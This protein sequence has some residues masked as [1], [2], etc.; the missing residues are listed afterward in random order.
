MKEPAFWMDGILATSVIEI[1]HDPAIL[2]E[3]SHEGFWAV[4]VNFEGDWT[5]VRFADIRDSPFP[6][7]EWSP[8]PA[9]WNSTLDEVEYRNYVEAIREAIAAGDFYQVNAC[10][11]LSRSFNGDLDG[12]FSRI[13][14]GNPAPYSAYFKVGDTEIASASP[15]LFLKMRSTDIGTSLTSSP[16]KGTSIDG[17]FGEKDRS[18]NVMIVDLIRNDLSQICEEGSVDVSRLLGVEEHP[19]LFHLVSDVTGTLKKDFNW[20]DFSGALLPAGSISGAPK[21][22]AIEFIQSHEPQ[23]G[24]YCGILGYIDTRGGKC[25]ALL[26]VAIRI[27]WLDK[28][29]QELKFGSGAGITWGSDPDGEWAET[30]L[31][32]SRLMRIA[33]G[34][35]VQ[36]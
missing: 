34:E 2:S 14:D 8:T 30:Q 6:Q 20:K 36:K 9:Q 7:N 16:I 22:S 24:P 19:G 32:A 33:D 29:K 26:S 10:R 21:S 35:V 12:L 31:K 13:L 4:Q 17:A 28:E 15:E 11:I 1:S 25:E 27:F 5:L 18:E 23:R 3:E